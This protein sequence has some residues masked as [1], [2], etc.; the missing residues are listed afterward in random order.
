MRN[1][2]KGQDA[3]SGVYD[4]VGNYG[5]TGNPPLMSMFLSGFQNSNYYDKDYNLGP[6]TDYNQITAF[7]N[8]NPG[9][10]PIDEPA[11]IFGSD[12]KQLQF[13]RTHFGWLRHEHDRI[14]TFPPA[15]RLAH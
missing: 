10:F 11:T 15:D 2:H 14:W 5:T 13:N 9:L 7:F 12:V 1:A 6:V 8:A 3:L 4:N